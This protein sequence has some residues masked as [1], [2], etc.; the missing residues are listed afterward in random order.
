MSAV[1]HP[2]IVIKIPFEGH[3]FLRTSGCITIIQQRFQIG[4]F[5]IWWACSE[6]RWEEVVWVPFLRHRSHILKRPLNFCGTS[7][8][9]SRKRLTG[10]RSFS[11]WAWFGSFSLITASVSIESTC[12]FWWPYNSSIW[13]SHVLKEVQII[14][15]FLL[16]G[17]PLKQ[18][19]ITRFLQMPLWWIFFVWFLRLM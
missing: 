18:I 3:S 5:V 12:K 19:S 10:E 1:I 7:R 15:I 11:Q 4:I 8:S 16:S 9:H 14:D 2:G 13:L 17:R 6:E